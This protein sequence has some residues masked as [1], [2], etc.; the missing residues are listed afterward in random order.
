MKIKRKSSVTRQ[1][2]EV[3]QNTLPHIEMREL[4]RKAK[5]SVVNSWIQETRQAREDSYQMALYAWNG[6]K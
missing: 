2:S 5:R 1:V 3:K 4:E 6:G